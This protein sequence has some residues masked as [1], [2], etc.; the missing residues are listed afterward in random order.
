[1][2]YDIS[3]LECAAMTRFTALLPI[4]PPPPPF[5]GVFDNK[6]PHFHKRPHSNI[7]I[8]EYRYALTVVHLPLIAH[9]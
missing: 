1:M 2:A 6:R 3:V 9:K 8:L 7:I 5:K 4:S